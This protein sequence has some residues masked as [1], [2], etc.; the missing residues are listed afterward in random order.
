MEKCCSFTH[1]TKPIVTDREGNV[2][3]LHSLCLTFT[4]IL[5]CSILDKI[6]QHIGQPTVNAVLLK[7][8]P[9]REHKH[10]AENFCYSSS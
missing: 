2:N 6:L 1:M 10:P 5:K 4:S 8:F 3:W 9:E 7:N